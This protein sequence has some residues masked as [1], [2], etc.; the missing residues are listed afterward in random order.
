MKKLFTLLMALPL[1]LLSLTTTS[2]SDDDKDLPDVDFTLQVEN[3]QIVDNTI[4]V[5]QGDTLKVTAIDV[6]AV[7]GSKDCGIARATYFIDGVIAYNTIFP[8]FGAEFPTYK[9]D[10]DQPGTSIGNHTMLIEMTVLQVK[11]EIGIA[12]LGYNIKVV[13]DESQIP[14]GGTTTTTGTAGIKAE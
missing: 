1:A 13:E 14:T 7:S 3:A 6:T 10:G 9:A 4:Y 2:S 12:A 11:K 8:P 5:V